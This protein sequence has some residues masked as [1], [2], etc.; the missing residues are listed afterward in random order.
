VRPAA[1]TPSTT[2]TAP[3]V[4][5]RPS[6]AFVA[7]APLEDEPGVPACPCA[8]RIAGGERGRQHFAVLAPHL[9]RQIVQLD[10]VAAGQRDS[11]LDQPFELAHVARPLVEPEG[12][13]GRL[14]QRQIA[15][16]AMPR[17]EV[18]RQFEHV[19]APLTKRRHMNVDAAQPVEEVGPEQP[20]RHEASQ[21]TIRGS[22]DACVHAARARGPHTLDRQILD[23]AQQLGL[24]GERQVRH[25]IEKQRAAVGVLELAA[26]AAHA[27]GGA[28]LDPEQL[29]LEQRLDDGG[30]VDRHKRSP[31]PAALLVDL[32]RDEL[33]AGA[34][35]TRERPGVG[36]S[37]WTCQRIGWAQGGNAHRPAKLWSASTQKTPAAPQWSQFQGLARAPARQ[38]LPTPRARQPRDPRHNYRSG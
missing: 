28:L 8:H 30:A 25:F 21:R 33:L 31:P 17:Q 23:G 15:R 37:S 2:D 1:P 10:A 38:R 36:N 29:R 24:R 12:V 5:C 4:T 13:H 34:A 20:A 26:P 9:G 32:S 6:K 35:F 22:D 16:G 7:A 3:P 27:G 19:F 11:P 14:G 18:H